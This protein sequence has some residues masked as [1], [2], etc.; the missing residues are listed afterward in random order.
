MYCPWMQ[1]VCDI[2]FYE[3]ACLHLSEIN[4]TV[5]VNKMIIT[6]VNTCYQLWCVYGD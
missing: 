3:I 6:C 2:M 5:M 1:Y 4:E